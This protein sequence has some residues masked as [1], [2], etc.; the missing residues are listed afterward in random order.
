MKALASLAVVAV[1]AVMLTGFSAP[2][3]THETDVQAL[4]DNEL[5]WNAD[6]A[7]HDIAKVVAHYADDGVLIVTGEKPFAGKAALTAAWTMMVSDPQFALVIHTDK[8]LVAESG[9]LGT[10]YGTYELTLHDP[11][12]KQLVHDTG[13]YVTT[14]R[15]A[16]DG[17]WKAVYD[18]PVSNIPMK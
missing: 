11:A 13:S 2:A 12:S 14:Y 16:A 7:S 15:K 8:V 9:E 1:S 6:F 10:T 4:K 3:K 18:V 17:S 5:Q